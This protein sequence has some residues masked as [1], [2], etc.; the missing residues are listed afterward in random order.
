MAVS[1]SAPNNYFLVVDGESSV[2]DLTTA[3]GSAIANTDSVYIATATTKGILGIQNAEVLIAKLKCG[4]HR[5]SPATITNSRGQLKIYAGGRIECP[6]GSGDDFS[7]FNEGYGELATSGTTSLGAAGTRANFDVNSMDE[8][9]LMKASMDVDYLYVYDIKSG[10][11]IDLGGWTGEM[12]HTEFKG[13]AD[14]AY[15]FKGIPG[16]SA[17]AR[18][19]DLNQVNAGLFTSSTY[20]D[21]DLEGEGSIVKV[22]PGRNSAFSGISVPGRQANR[23]FKGSVNPG[24][25][26]IMYR[27]DSGNEEDMIKELEIMQARCQQFLAVIAAKGE[28]QEYPNYY[29]FRGRLNNPLQ[30]YNAG[31]DFRDIMI[32]MTEDP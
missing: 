4:W 5:I 26:D 30:V 24:T 14:A 6:L 25:Y 19:L 2:A 8:I 17:F 22:S 7:E 28:T 29:L 32:T 12:Y 23:L 21:I 15:S 10:Q 9:V 16:N 18:G 31:I 1:Y 27:V 20:A 3:K 11:E 13:T